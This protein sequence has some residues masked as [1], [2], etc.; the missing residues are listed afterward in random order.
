MA[1][2]LALGRSCDRDVRLARARG[3]LLFRC[4]RYAQPLDVVVV[5][6]GLVIQMIHLGRGL[7]AVHAAMLPETALHVLVAAAL[8]GLG[9]DA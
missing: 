6:V 3:Q 5:L 2:R 1:R 9:P 4:A 7:L 8:A